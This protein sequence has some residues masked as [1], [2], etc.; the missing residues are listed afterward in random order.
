MNDLEW[1]TFTKALFASFPDT[2]QWLVSA[3]LKDES[4]IPQVK[5]TLEVW[6]GAIGDCTLEE[7][8]TVLGLFNREEIQRPAFQERKDLPWIIAR[9]VRDRR[10]ASAPKEHEDYIAER[11]R[12]RANYKQGPGMLEIWN[13]VESANR[14]LERGEISEAEWQRIKDGIG[15]KAVAE[16]VSSR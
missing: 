15:S 9:I 6:R 8:R 11:D 16:S 13:A 1:N 3:C 10:K 5:A 14:S 2:W 7:C 4:G 12:A